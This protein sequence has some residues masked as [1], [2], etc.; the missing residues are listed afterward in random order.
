[1]TLFNPNTKVFSIGPLRFATWGGKG[2][3]MR[4]RGFAVS[5]NGKRRLISFDA[6]YEGRA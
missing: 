6:Y 1:M 3:I 5:W 4:T 2:Y